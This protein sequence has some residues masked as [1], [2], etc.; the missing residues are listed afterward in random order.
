[1]LKDPKRFGL[2][3]D[4]GPGVPVSE[5]GTKGALKLCIDS[6]S[7]RNMCRCFK[8]Q[9]IC[10]KITNKQLEFTAASTICQRKIGWITTGSQLRMKSNVKEVQYDLFSSCPIV[11]ELWSSLQRPKPQNARTLFQNGFPAV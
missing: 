2:Y 3:L 5:V 9:K 8:C 6:V 7:G 4:L 11:Q 1:V 10:T